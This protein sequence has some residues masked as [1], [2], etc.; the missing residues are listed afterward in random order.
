VHY[1]PGWFLHLELRITFTNSSTGWFVCSFCWRSS[2]PGMS[3]WG[4]NNNDRSDVLCEHCGTN[5]LLKAHGTFKRDCEHEQWIS[6][7]FLQPW[8]LWQSPDV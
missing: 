5:R 6:D 7:C 2:S 8:K 3:I 4:Y 1:Y